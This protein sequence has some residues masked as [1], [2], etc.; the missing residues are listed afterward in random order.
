VRRVSLTDS[1][2]AAI[3]AGRRHR[4]GLGAE[5]AERLGPRRVEAAR[6]LLADVAAEHGA[7]AAVRSRRVGSPR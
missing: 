6:R 4:T 2:R 3:E 5:L 7:D 1:G